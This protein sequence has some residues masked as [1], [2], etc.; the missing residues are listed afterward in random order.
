[1]DTMNHSIN[2]DAQRLIDALSA[3]R[4]IAVAFSGGVDS[5][6]VA[7]AAQ[8]A[9]VESAIAVTAQSP[10][11]PQW[12]LEVARKVAR[13]IGIEHRIVLTGEGDRED[14]RRNDRRRCFYCKDTLYQTIG[15]LVETG[16]ATTIVSGTNADDLG[17]YRP[18]I[19]AGTDRGVVTPLADLG[20]G[21]AKVRLLADVFGCPTATCRLH[22]V[23]Q[24]EG[25]MAPR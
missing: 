16:D 2:D 21:K 15:Q 14:Y 6:V 24:A 10:S 4:R 3:H 20:F 17:D 18:G 8:R 9:D 13:E 19:A 23:W 11:V 1:M 25:R 5:S 7:A 22:R 12:Q